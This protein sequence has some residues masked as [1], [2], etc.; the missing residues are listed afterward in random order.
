MGENADENPDS[1]LT[2]TPREALETP[3]EEVVPVV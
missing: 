3:V 1:F 2:K